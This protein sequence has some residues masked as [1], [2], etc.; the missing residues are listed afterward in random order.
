MRGLPRR[1]MIRLAEAIMIASDKDNKKAFR[2]VH[3]EREKR[4]SLNEEESGAEAI[5]KVRTVRRT[6]PRSTWE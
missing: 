3:S 5:W 4:G 1:I 2:L 6:P